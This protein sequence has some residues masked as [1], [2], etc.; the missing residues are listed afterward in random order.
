MRHVLT[1]VT[2]LIV[3]SVIIVLRFRY[4]SGMPAA[5]LSVLSEIALARSHPKQ[6]RISE[7]KGSQEMDIEAFYQVIIDNNIFRPLDWKPPQYKPAYTLLGTFIATDG[8]SSTAYI[9]EHKSDLFYAVSVGKQVGDLFVT[10][11]TAKRV[12]L[13]SSKGKTLQ[14]HFGGPRFLAS[15]GDRRA[16]S[17]SGNESALS[18]TS[19]KKIETAQIRT[20]EDLRKHFKEKTEAIRSE[21]NRMMERLRYLQQR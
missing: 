10:V 17:P 20:P 15:K 3:V 19:A 9:H 21:R 11:I 8:S 12:T 1:I 4:R 18:V 13:T 14:L 16:P 7:N 2:I 6:A 5:P